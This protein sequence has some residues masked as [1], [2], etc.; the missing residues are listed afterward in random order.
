M[1]RSGS[2]CTKSASCKLLH[3]CS[4]CKEDTMKTLIVT[5]ITVVALLFPFT[6][7]AELTERERTLHEMHSMMRMMDNALCEALEGANLLMFGQM[8]GVEKIN[9]DMVDRGTAMVK[10]G[11]AVISKILAGAEMKAMHKEGGYNEKIMRDLHAL[12]DRMLHVIEEVEKL[13]AEAFQEM[14]KK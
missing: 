11:K 7:Q 12:G 9:R 10:D 13:H 4:M 8:S 14:G 2:M 3:I 6:V 1:I 5:V